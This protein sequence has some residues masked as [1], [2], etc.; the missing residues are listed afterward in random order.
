MDLGSLPTLM[1]A[2]RP[3]ASGG[4][5]RRRLRGPLGGGSQ[6][7]LAWV[8]RADR[9][10]RA[11][12]GVVDDQAE[13]S[14][15]PPASWRRR[16]ARR[17]RRGRRWSGR[18]PRRRRPACRSRALTA[19]RPNDCCGRYGDQVGRGV[20][21][22]SSAWATGARTAPRREAELGAELRQRLGVLEAGAG[23][24]A[25]DRDHQPD[26][27]VGLAPS[28]TATARAARRAPSAAGSAG[29]HQRRRSRQPEPAA[30]AA[31]SSGG[32]R[33]VDAGVHHLDPA[34]VGVVQLDQLLGL[35]SAS[36]ITCRR[37]RPS[38]P[39]RSSASPARGCRPRPACRS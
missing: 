25:D 32:R 10:R 36:A 11:E 28:S 12:T 9:S 1:S 24:A 39:H 16:A 5:R 38:V 17:G 21:L 2:E 19:T 18:R 3:R 35:E 20:P 34:G 37:P 27:S 31:L 23:R 29:E 8:E 22:A 4:W 26:R 7:T 6:E 33:Q 15:Q 30:T 13:A 14:A